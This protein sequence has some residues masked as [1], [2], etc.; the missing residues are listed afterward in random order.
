MREI[1]CEFGQVPVQ[2]SLE[3]VGA[4][5]SSEQNTS[6]N[7]PLLGSH[8]HTHTWSHSKKVLSENQ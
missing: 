1:E 3:L 2:M 4:I 7:Y 5:L 6:I 8:F